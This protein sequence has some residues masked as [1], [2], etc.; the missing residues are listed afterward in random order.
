MK[1]CIVGAGAIGGLLAAKLDAAGE[2]VSLVARGAHLAAIRQDGLTLIDE[3]GERTSH[4]EAT[5]RMAD[6]GPQDLVILGLKAHQVADVVEQLP[7]LYGPDTMVLTAQNGIPWWYFF[8]HGGPLADRTLTSVDPEGRVARAI[9]IKRMTLDNGNTPPRSSL[10]EAAQANRE[11][12][13]ANLLM[14][15]PALRVDLF[16]SNTRP[17][18]TV[19]ALTKDET[20]RFRLANRKHDIEASAILLDGEFIV[21]AGSSARLRWE[22]QNSEGKRTN[23]PLVQRRNKLIT[24]LQQQRALAEDPNLIVITQRWRKSEDGGKRLVE[25]Q[26][27][28]KRWWALAKA[29][30]SSVRDTENLV[31]ICS[32]LQGGDRYFGGTW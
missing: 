8:K 3:T 7:A 13:L 9:P 32:A 5:D 22:G 19:S 28:V 6:L 17:P 16:I 20:P 26:K 23:D 12:F 18:V 27:R 1:I 25:R 30:R 14:V 2:S 11:G 31:V 10:S 24:Q 21:E 29:C 4:L 15:L